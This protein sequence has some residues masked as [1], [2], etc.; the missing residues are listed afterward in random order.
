MPDRCG[1]RQRLVEMR[2]G[3]RLDHLIR[4]GAA[5]RAGFH[6]GL[7]LGNSSRPNLA[8]ITLGSVIVM[9]ASPVKRPRVTFSL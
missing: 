5:R 2:Q 4:P 6:E 3:L 9:G 1:P 7:D 8:L